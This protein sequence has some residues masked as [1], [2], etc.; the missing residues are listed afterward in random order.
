MK[1]CSDGSVYDGDWKYGNRHGRGKHI[2]IN[3]SVY[4]GDW[5]DDFQ[6]APTVTSPSLGIIDLE[7]RI[8]E[9]GVVV[10]T[11]NSLYSEDEGEYQ[12]PA[13]AKI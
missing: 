6:V 10:S 5:K 1:T 9:E 2:A 4:D 3:G 8:S 7:M 11:L 13:K 12:L